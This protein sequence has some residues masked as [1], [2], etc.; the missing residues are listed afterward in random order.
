ML[1][2]GLIFFIV[3][4]GLWFG[5][6]RR[7]FLK[8]RIALN[9][10]RRAPGELVCPECGGVLARE[11]DSGIEHCRCAGCSSRWLERAA[12]KS[13]VARKNKPMR[14][15][16]PEENRK[17]L[18]CPK[19]A[20]SMPGGVFRGEDFPVYQCSPCAAFW[21]SRDE[22]ISLGLRVLN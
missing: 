18:S 2:L 6:I 9:Q 12:L 16:F 17:A 20:G 4:W 15:W 8:S 13:A 7:A 5:P 14:E 22:W 10:A 21:L 11:P 3:F 1:F 19:C